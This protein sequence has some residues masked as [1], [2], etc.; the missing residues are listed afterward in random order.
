MNKVRR[1]R[2]GTALLFLL[3]IL[4]LAAGLRFFRLDAQSFWNDEGNSARIA[5]RPLTAIIAGAAGDIH[6]PGYYILLAG[7]RALVGRSEFALRSL[8][9]LVGVLTVALMYAVGLRLFERRVG[10][11][12]ALLVAANPFQVYYGQEA[13]MYALLA[14]L[15]AASIRLTAAVLALPDEM[16]TSRRG[17]R[18]FRGRRAAAILVG[19][20]LVNVAGLYTHYSF[21][22]VILAETLVFVA[23]LVR[24][25]KRL[26]GLAMWIGLQLATL[27]LFAPWLPHAAR[28]VM[29]WPDRGVAGV[30]SLPMVL[31]YGGTL[32][33]DVARIGVVPLLLGAIVGLLPPFGPQ[34]PR[35]SPR[36]AERVGL[37]AAWLLVPVGLLIAVDAV[38]GPVLKFL[39]PANLALMLLVARG[40]VM[41]FDLGRPVPGAGPGDDLLARIAAMIL[42]AVGLFPLLAGLYGL[43]FDPAYA[44]D[45]YRAIAE[46]IRSESGSQAAVVLVAP[47]QWEVFTYY[48]PDGPNI[49]PLP[50]SHTEETLARLLGEHRRIYVLYW[51]AAEQDPQGI[52]R[53]TLETNAFKVV[54]GWYGGVQFVTYAVPGEPTIEAV[55]PGEVL[56]GRVITLERFALSADTLSPGEALGVTLFW[57]AD[58]SLDVRY[59][60]FVHLYAP[61]GSLVTQHDSEPG[62]D[63]A[64]TDSWQ[65][66]QVVA[67][68]HGLLLPRRA[69]TGVYRLVVGLYTFEGERL[70]VTQD[71]RPLGDSLLLCE[72]VVE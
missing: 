70:T 28:Q 52:V 19:Y 44:R 4:I 72:I 34:G 61:D 60:V 32:P 36:F 20:V 5:E 55:P 40:A 43:Y 51:G 46:H 27:I 67:D 24:R 18:P 54:S 50:D 49:A 35:R 64:P 25:K 45:N 22:F 2:P 57:R 3:V 23:W 56:F 68:N 13:R 41:G 30:P 16:A 17:G 31:A 71:G 11:V 9:A 1:E 33:Y 65:P 21:P 48:Y 39:L 8:S 37:V 66:G 58:T 42:M 12:A 63:L 6:P 7:W 26:H 10:V 29:I 14:L 15:S 69:A 62:G 47:N 38:S 59:K 53:G